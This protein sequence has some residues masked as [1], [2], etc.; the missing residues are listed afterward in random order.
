[1]TDRGNVGILPVVI[2]ILALA[3]GVLHFS[4]DFILFRG[5]IFGFGRPP[6]GA[7]PGGRPPGP[8]PGG[9][10]AVPMPLP[11]NELFLLNLI[12][13]IVLVILF[14]LG[15][16][17]FGR[18]RWVID[19]AMIIFAALTILGWLD[20]GHP[21]PMGLGYLAKAIELVLIVVLFAHL[22][23]IV[24]QRYAASPVA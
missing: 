22:G 12:G 10:P 15:P 13:W 6:G 16:S 19:A 18:A 9:G 24:G 5:N 11:L 21:N 2:T 7:P 23:S 20:I 8:P 14:W 1:M 3:D 17:L 4:L